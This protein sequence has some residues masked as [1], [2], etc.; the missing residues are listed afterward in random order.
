M[1]V[2][3]ALE[4]PDTFRFELE[5]LARQLQGKVRGRFM[6]PQSYHV[7]LA[8]LGD[9]D[10]RGVDGACA[11]LDEACRGISPV[12]IAPEGLGTFGKP[13][14]ATLWLGIAPEDALMTLCRNV[15]E[16]LDARCIAFDAK[17]F[18]P[19][20]TLARRAAIPKAPLGSLPFP[21]ATLACAVTL[22]KSDLSAEGAVYSPLH[23]VAL[24]G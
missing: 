6:P 1:R 16:Q 2:F 22:F 11:A 5:G 9:I 21:E 18:K 3:V 23:V 12:C 14:D 20:V 7:T 24:D 13:R 4:L 17:P 15:R 8:F 19:H 10:N